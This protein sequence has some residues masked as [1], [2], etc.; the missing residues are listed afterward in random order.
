MASEEPARVNGKAK[1]NRVTAS[2]GA[3]VIR[4][5]VLGSSIIRSIHSDV[6]C[7]VG[8]WVKVRLQP[9]LGRRMPSF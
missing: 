9:S 7:F 1:R 2:L 4:E 8:P 6:V 3:W 5:K